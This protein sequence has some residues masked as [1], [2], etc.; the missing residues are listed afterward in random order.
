MNGRQNDI[1]LKETGLRVQHLST[2]LDLII[3]I[4]WGIV[5]AFNEV[6]NIHFDYK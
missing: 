2:A 3:N 4:N 6:K 5:R 1:C